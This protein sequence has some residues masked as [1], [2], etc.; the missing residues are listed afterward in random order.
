MKR[1]FAV[2]LVSGGMDS[3]VTCG[4]AQKTY[5][6]A[7]LHINYGQRT[8]IKELQSFHSL[9]DFYKV[10]ERLVVDFTHFEKI[11]G[12]SLIDRRIDIPEGLS[13]KE[14]PSTYVPFRNAQ[15]LS[16]AVSWAEI[17]G[18]SV[19]FSGV[20]EEDAAG[21]PDCRREFFEIF[22]K[23][24]KIGT[25]KDT[26]IDIL[27]PLMSMMKKDITLLGTKLGVPFELTWSC[28]RNNDVACGR[29]DSCLR[30]LRAFK[31][32]GIGDK[33]EYELQTQDLRP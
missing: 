1:K 16:V 29:C 7:F 17:I 5:N 28:Y 6:L 23:L 18:A 20:T 8:E 15:F 19:V 11:G 13:D 25:K 22:S 3:A 21:Y 2:V 33:I 24:V 32:A 9:A 12:T 30:R 14:T 31:K 27:T 26:K 10:K 4:I